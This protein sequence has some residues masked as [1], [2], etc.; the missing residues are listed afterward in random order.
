MKIGI[1]C[2]LWSQT[3]VGRYI[4]NLVLELANIDNKNEYVLFVRSEDFDQV[5]S[6]VSNS[7]FSIIKVNVKWHSLKE[8]ILFPRLLNKCNLDIIHFPY[9][10]VPIFYNKPFVVTIHDLII[11]HFP[12]GKAS[13]MPLTLY[14]LKWL[15]YQVVLNHALKK[16]K[17]IIVPL[18]FVKND[19]IR[20]LKVPKEKIEV[21]TEGFDIAISKGEA[22]KEI[23]KITKNP[24]FIYVGNAYPHKNLEKLIEG[25]YKANLKNINLIFVGKDDYFYKRIEKEKFR[26][27][28]FLHDVTD[29]QLFYLYSNS[30]AAV[31]A[32]LMEGF[33]LLP[34][35]ALSCGTIPVISNIP[36]FNEVCFDAAIY[37]KPE[38]ANDIADKLK[39]AF[40]LRKT[41]R[42]KIMEK[43]K[44]L[45]KKFSFSQMAKETL[46]IY[47][48]SAGLR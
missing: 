21:A 27:I 41:D 43:G 2:R 47:E 1:D 24:Y 13:T 7:R 6:S 23:L 9:F 29:S 31:S 5:K 36:A 4:K 39:K 30:I 8:Q 16:S 19:L 46:K 33:G 14:A 15:S 40:N 12:T 28:I 48:S 17:K 11:N 22:S 45:A 42:E 20:T 35:E 25:F 10:S 38:D 34:L 26:N 18:E 37:F 3:G 44:N 32:S